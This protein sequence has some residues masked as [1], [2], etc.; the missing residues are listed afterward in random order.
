MQA[1]NIEILKGEQGIQGPKGVIGSSGP[2]G[3]ARTDGQY[4]DLVTNTGSAN[5]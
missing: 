3:P 1:Y 4:A 2:A 5:K